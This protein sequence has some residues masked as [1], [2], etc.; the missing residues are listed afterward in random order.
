MHAKLIYILNI[1]TTAIATPLH[2][3]SVTGKSLS[4]VVDNAVDTVSNA[5]TGA[6]QVVREVESVDSVF[7]ALEA[8]PSIANDIIVNNTIIANSALWQEALAFD[9][10]AKAG[11]MNQMVYRT[12]AYLQRVESDPHSSESGSGWSPSMIA[13]V[14]QAMHVYPTQFNQPQAADPAKSLG[15]T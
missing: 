1:L 9:A 7:G 10:K 12:I 3:E 2:Q 4:S 6:S 11:T 5:V 8:L 15:K 13:K 14:L